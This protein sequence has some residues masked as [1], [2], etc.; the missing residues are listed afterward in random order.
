MTSKILAAALLIFGQGAAIAAEGN[1]TAAAMKNPVNDIAEAYVKL[2]LAMGPH[3]KDYVDAFYGPAEWK[4]AVEAEKKSLPTIRAGALE[5]SSR[6]A[7]LPVPSEEMN[8]L[9]LDYLTKQ[10]SALEARVRILQGERLKFDDEARALYDAVAPTQPESH[11]QKILEQ[12][13]TKIPGKGPLTQ[14]YE[15]WRAQFVI[16]RE[17]LDA[18]FQLAIKECRTRTLAHIKLPASES[19]TVEYV[20]GKSWGGY[21][22]YQGN[23]R[24]LI[25]VNTDLPS[26]IDRAVDLAAHEGYPG[27]H[28]YNALLEKN[29]VRDR[30]WIEFSVYPL[31]SPQSLIA[32]GT[33]NFGREVAFT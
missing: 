17:K 19:F 18:V 27:H 11:F 30:G 2:V 12:L 20:T 33:A 3:D 28:V 26:Y 14:R 13:E 15:E 16:P 24:S 22:W 23:Y 29:L 10:L 5:L 1:E 7:Q 4:I 25:Q 32:E 31:F 9:R 8:R 21:N 6:L